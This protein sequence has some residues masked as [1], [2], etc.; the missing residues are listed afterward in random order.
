MR[1]WALAIVPVIWRDCVYTPYS[2][3]HTFSSAS[4]AACRK[5]EPWH[6]QPGGLLNQGG[7]GHRKRQPYLCGRR[8]GKKPGGFRRFNIQIT[9]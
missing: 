9:R 7:S 6:P 2:P 4:R 3:V 8:V 1:R 5:F